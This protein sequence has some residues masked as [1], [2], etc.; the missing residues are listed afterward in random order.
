MHKDYVNEYSIYF[1][2]LAMNI[3]IEVKILT[4]YICKTL[5]I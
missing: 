5:Q 1:K 2:F 4:M 3:F